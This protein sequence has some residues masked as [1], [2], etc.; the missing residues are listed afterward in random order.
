[1]AVPLCRFGL[2]RFARYGRGTRRHDDRRFGMTLG[3]G[4]RNVSS[5]AA[6]G[7]I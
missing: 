5:A 2:R 6:T 3:R 1:M 4:G 7:Q